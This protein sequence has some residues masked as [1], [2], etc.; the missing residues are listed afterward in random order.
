[1]QHGQNKGR[2]WATGRSSGRIDWWGS[3]SAF[4]LL[5]PA[6]L[7]ACDLI[8]LADLP[9]PPLSLP[10]LV[11]SL[12][13]CL[14]GTSVIGVCDD[15]E[16]HLTRST[17]YLKSGHLRN[18][19]A[20]LEALTPPL[21][22]W[23][24]ENGPLDEY[25]AEDRQ[26]LEGFYALLEN[27]WQSVIDQCRVVESPAGSKPE[28]VAGQKTTPLTRTSGAEKQAAQKLAG[29]AQRRRLTMGEL[30]QHELAFHATMLADAK[31]KL[32]PTVGPMFSDPLRLLNKKRTAATATA[33]TT[34]GAAAAAATPTLAATAAAVA[35]PATPS[36]ASGLPSPAGDKKRKQ[37]PATDEATAPAAPS[38][39]VKMSDEEVAPPSPSK[40]VPAAKPTPEDARPTKKLKAKK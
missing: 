27:A 10:S 4:S 40:E 26:C 23:S 29:G 12:S 11:R 16:S 15:L 1:M 28:G 3:S 37:Q 34:P 25:D 8:S 19:V 31:K 17:D 5:L 18:A 22:A 30:A 38:T 24:A 36:A 21:V 9:T 2:A 39:E 13:V 32:T 7:A 6:C 20:I 33:A 35:T 14:Q